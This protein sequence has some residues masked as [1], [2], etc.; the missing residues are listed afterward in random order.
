MIDVQEAQEIVLENARLRPEIELPASEAAGHFLTRELIAPVSHPLFDQAAVDGYGFRFLD[1]KPE[2]EIRKL[3]VNGEIKA[4]DSPDVILQPG[5]AVRIF[6]GAALPYGV[7][8]VVMQEY[9]THEQAH[10]RI[11]DKLIKSGENVRLKGEQIRQGDVAIEAGSFLDA[12]AIGFACSLGISSLKVCQKPMVGIT[13]TGSE[14]AGSYDAE[15]DGKIFESNSAMLLAALSAMG[16][17]GSAQVCEDNPKRLVRNI[18]KQLDQFDTLIMTGGVSVGAYDHTQEVLEELG[19]EIL[20]HGVRQKPGRPMLFARQ[21]SKFVFGLP[22]NPRAALV[23]FYAYV[24]PFLN[25][26]MGAK[27]PFLSEISLLTGTAL[28]TRQG[29]TEFV[30]GKLKAG[31]FDPSEGQ[32]SHLLRTF[33]E[34]LFLAILAPE[35]ERILKGELIRAWILP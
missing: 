18:K 7:D 11:H 14:F 16:L 28:R 9:V 35:R 30:S 3:E 27:D 19:F 23:C 5:Q 1:L 21:G 12:A 20:F 4:G 6:T 15:R 22:G 17:S 25:R 8:T 32:N 29:R 33:S 31:M 10:I 13:V 2:T 26:Q 24:L 34:S